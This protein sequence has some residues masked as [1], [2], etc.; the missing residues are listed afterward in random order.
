MDP[1]DPRGLSGGPV[2]SSI[3]TEDGGTGTEIAVGVVRGV[4]VGRYAATSLGGGLIATRIEDLIPRLPQI[5]AALSGDLPGSPVEPRSAAF[6]EDVLALLRKLDHQACQEYLPAYLPIGADVS[7][8]ARTVRLLGRVRRPDDNNKIR[9][10]E[11]KATADG[12]GGSDPDRRYEY[13]ADRADRTNDP[14]QP[15]EGVI[16][17][18]KRLVVLADPGMGK[19]WL[20][21]SETH[22]LARAVCVSLEDP[23]TV[24]SDVVIPIPVRADVLA[25]SPGP[26]LAEAVSYYLVSEGLLESRSKKL[27]EQQIVRGG[28]VLLIDAL[29]EIPRQPLSPGARTSR[30]RLQDLLRHW[31]E[32]CTGITKCVMTSRLAG[33]RRDAN[34]GS[35]RGRTAAIQSGRC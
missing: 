29:D 5:A 13:P 25:S 3:Y 15:L 22:R 11:G 9:Q 16:L 18:H 4:P 14:P 30:K 24:P 8:M 21:R 12:E 23:A 7:G 10:Q 6:K 19:S 35:A 2:L 33:L 17:A 20:L 32:H 26:T 27:I 1:V 28:V 31:V 34:T